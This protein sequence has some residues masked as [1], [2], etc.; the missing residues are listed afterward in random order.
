MKLLDHH[1]YEAGAADSLRHLIN[2]IARAGKYI[3]YALQ[4]G[5]LGKAGSSNWFGEEQLALDVLADRTL[6]ENIMVCRLT[7]AAISEEQEAVTYCPHCPKSACS[8]DPLNF[9]DTTAIGR[10]D[11][12]AY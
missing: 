3:N 10:C 1:L 5:D 7:S 4:M 2:Y 11:Y 9:S 8:R 6:M 12:G